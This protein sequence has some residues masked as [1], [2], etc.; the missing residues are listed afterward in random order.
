MSG[1]CKANDATQA[2]VNCSYM[3]IWEG[4]MLQLNDLV[5]PS[6]FPWIENILKPIWIK[7]WTL[8]H[9]FSACIIDLY[10]FT[11]F[12]NWL[13]MIG[14]ELA[15]YKVNRI[16]IFDSKKYILKTYE[17]PLYLSPVF[18]KTA[19]CHY[20]LSGFTPSSLYWYVAVAVFESLKIDM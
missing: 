17:W 12:V 20:Y 6:A 10:E 13:E 14:C 4:G 18:W 1:C 9:C 19:S 3:L 5:Q 11:F 8:L 7:P 2:I 16:K 15:L